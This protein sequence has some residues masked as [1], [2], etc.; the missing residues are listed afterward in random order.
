M[1]DFQDCQQNKRILFL[2][3]LIFSI[4]GK[5]KKMNQIKKPS[6]VDCIF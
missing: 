5:K 6:M 3:A 4:G 2:Q 1:Y